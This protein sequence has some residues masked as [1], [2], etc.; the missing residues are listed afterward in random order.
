MARDIAERGEREEDPRGQWPGEL[1]LLRAR[2]PVPLR[3]LAGEVDALGAAAINALA[4][5]STWTVPERP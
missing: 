3:R 2:E 4:Q 5:A 1:L